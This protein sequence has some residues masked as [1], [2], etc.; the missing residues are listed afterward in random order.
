MNSSNIVSE[1]SVP[2]YAVYISQ[3]VRHSNNLCVRT[4]ISCYQAG[5]R[6]S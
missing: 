2:E 6:S 3:L 1:N 4:A 5:G